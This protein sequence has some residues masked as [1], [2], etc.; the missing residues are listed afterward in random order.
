MIIDPGLYTRPLDG[1]KDVVAIAIT[2]RHDDHCDEDQLRRIL[3]V[4]PS[5]EIFG[6]AEVSQRLSE[7]KVTTVCHGDF[8][9]VGGFSLEFF[10][11]IHAEI[12]QSIPLIQN[13]GVMINDRL[14]YPGD[15][16]TEPDRAVEILACPTSAPW[17]KISEVMDFVAA[18]KPNNC[19]A[20]H[21]IHLSE[22]GHELQNGR[23]R[24]VV[25]AGGGKF[26]FLAPGES[27]TL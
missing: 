24:E 7:F 3:S 10:G 2:H 12:H 22:I 15:S 13:C 5:A 25:E 16:F 9:K 21:N 4:S 20:T 26:L 11:D 17:L 8:F 6:T 18:V 19:F 27:T 1:Y 23:V 14:Y